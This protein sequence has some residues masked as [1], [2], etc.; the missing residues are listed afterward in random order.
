MG[1][2]RSPTKNRQ[3]R[4]VGTASQLV[5]PYFPPSFVIRNSSLPLA[6]DAGQRGL[7]LLLEAGDQFAVGGDQRLLGFDLGYD[8][9]L[10]GEGWKGDSSSSLRMP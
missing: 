2:A 9:L 8:S 3:K 4:I 7:N 10:R 5:P 1:Q 6:P